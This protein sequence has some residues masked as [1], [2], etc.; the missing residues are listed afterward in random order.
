MGWAEARLQEDAAIGDGLQRCWAL[1]GESEPYE[2][3][4]AEDRQDGSMG[5]GT[6]HHAW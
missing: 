3:L 2:E 5:R 4:E 6:C 1:V